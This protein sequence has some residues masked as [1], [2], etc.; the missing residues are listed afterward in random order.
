MVTD[1]NV[2]INLI[3][4]NCLDILGQFPGYEF[5]VLEEVIAE[6]CI[7]EQAKA[8]TEAFDCQHLKREILSGVPAL[9]LYSEL[10][11]AMGKGEAA[12]LAMAVVSGLLIACDE[13]KV[14]LREAQQRLGP[15]RILT[16]PG[17]IVLAI[18]AGLMSIDQAD[19]IKTLLE[20]KRFKMTFT[21]FGEVV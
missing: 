17:I 20:T 13:K 11:Q 8:L 10:R 7:P 1:A 14:F 19:A 15:D 2:L 5:M 12:S 16:T 9:T 4:G 18:R 6:I 3:H 21:S